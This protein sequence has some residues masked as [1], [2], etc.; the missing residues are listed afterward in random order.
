MKELKGGMLLAE[1]ERR[2]KILAVYPDI[3]Q[4]LD[5]YPGPPAVAVPRWSSRIVF[6]AGVASGEIREVKPKKG[7]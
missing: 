1:G 5:Y 2:Y 7:G 6:E 3:I 4:Y